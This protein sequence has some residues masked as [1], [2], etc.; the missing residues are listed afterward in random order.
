[1]HVLYVGPQ[2]VEGLRGGLAHLDEVGEV[3]DSPE[4][5]RAQLLH[6]VKAAGGRVAVDG[7]LVLVEQHRVPAPG[8]LCHGGEPVHDLA[9][10]VCRV[11]VLGQVEAEHAEI[12]GG[13]LLLYLQGAL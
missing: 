13:E 4:V 3:E 5:F 6:Y 11:G 8:L 7:L 12:G 10:V 2:H 9:A 1:M